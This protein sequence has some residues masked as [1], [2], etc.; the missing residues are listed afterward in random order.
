MIDPAAK[1]AALSDEQLFSSDIAIWQGEG[2]AFR[3]E[4]AKRQQAMEQE[5]ARIAQELMERLS[6][7]KNA[8]TYSDALATEICERVSAGELLLIICEEPRMPTVRKA[9]CWLKE[10]P[11]FQQL[12]NASLNDRLSIFEEQIIAISDDVKNDF[13]TVIKRGQ[14]KR[15]SDPEQIA[16]AKLRVEAR[17]KYL[18]AFKPQRWGE[19]STLSVKSAD[20]FDPSNFSQ[21]ELERQIAEIEAKSAKPARSVA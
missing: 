1:F 21:E 17:I 18:R 15:V 12:Y 19:Q 6:A 4:K 13:R 5:Q 7:A 11:E 16:R 8:V 9:Y 10:S 2:D 3:A 20:E 14:T